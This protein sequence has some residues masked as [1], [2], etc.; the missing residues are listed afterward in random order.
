MKRPLCLGVVLFCIVVV[1]S[2][3]V[4]NNE[5]IADFLKKSSITVSGCV[6]EKRTF[7]YFG[8]TQIELVLEQVFIETIGAYP[9]QVQVSMSS[10]FDIKLGSIIL[11]K[12]AP[13]VF[14]RATNY[15]Q[16]DARSYYTNLGIGFSLKKATLI[17]QSSSYD[18]IKE[19]L[20]QKKIA[21]QKIYNT[22]LGE[23]N[24]SVLSAMILG[25][26]K[27]MDSELKELYQLS[28]IAHILAI[29][30]L[31]ITLIGMVIYRCL[32][33]FYLPHTPAFLI[34]MLFLFLY[35][36]MIGISPS[37]FR[38]FIMFLMQ[39]FSTVVKRSYDTVTS[40]MCFVFLILIQNPSYLFSVGVLLSVSAILG[41]SQLVPALKE[42]YYFESKI[43]KTILFSFLSCLGIF[44]T[45]LPVLLYYY[46]E[47]PI[48]SILL[49]VCILPFVSILIIGGMILLF[50]GSFPFLF[51]SLSIFLGNILSAIFY[52]YEVLSRISLQIPFQRVCIGK[53]SLS[54]IMCYFILL[55]LFLKIHT[56]RKKKNKKQTTHIVIIIIACSFLCFPTKKEFKITVLDVG[57]GD[58][59]VIETE[60][61][62]VY[63]VDGGSSSKSN[64][65]KNI[66]LPYLKYHGY[67]T[68]DGIFVSHFDKDHTN[69]IE[70]LIAFSMENKVTIKQVF[71]PKLE[72]KDESYLAFLE[73]C[74][75]ANI[76]VVAMAQK[77]YLVDGLLQ[78][79]CF[80]PKQKEIG[81][82]KNESSMVLYVEYKEFQGLL[83]GDLEGEGE[84]YLIE[85]GS[86]VELDFLKI[87]HHGSKFSTSED[88]LEKYTP[89]FA[90]ISCG[91]NNSYG[92]PSPIVLE[93]LLSLNI[94]YYIT[95][96]K[97]ALE[98]SLQ[99]K[100]GIKVE[101]FLEEKY[102]HK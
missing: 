66:I 79:T 37:F 59:I 74:Q 82:N 67:T 22:Y 62:T 10:D 11:V 85:N 47:V 23:E 25:L 100:G 75:Q 81:V 90:I 92:H 70:E 44:L 27:E 101:S 61:D 41:A 93:R 71:L 64:V 50:F 30:G 56:Q 42:L 68:I 18:V 45:T 40:L 4:K 1:I 5:E 102:L 69:G 83:T 29:S 84:L 65:G 8:T 99:K 88:F 3:R 2:F 77:D 17:S 72:E 28:G 78:I 89:Q 80:Y 53:P 76:P 13:T 43:I 73:L 60:H 51:H 38:A 54:K 21:F 52:Y 20:F 26:K 46:Y 35:G 94:P 39:M 12:G 63:L 6:V 36:M 32:R 98:I 49:N 31:H 58:G 24:G 95:M 48:F 97:G 7:E 86:D 9:M 91:E 33:F 19:F 87:A 34:A 16:F 14:Q 15:G 55:S 96:D 57:Q